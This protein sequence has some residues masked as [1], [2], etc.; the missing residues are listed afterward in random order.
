VALAILVGIGGG[1]AF[2]AH[3][4]AGRGAKAVSGTRVAEAKARAAKQGPRALPREMRGVH[5]TMA[6][7]SLHGKL[8]EYV[9]LRRAGLNTIELDVKD[10]NGEVG[11]VKG[12]PALA[13][14][15]GAAKPYYNARIAAR[16]VHAADLYLIG[17][18]VTFQDPV[19]SERRPGLAL[20]DPDGAV[21]HTRAGFGW[22][23][24]YDRR[25]WNYDV[26]VATAA[27]H[28]GFDEIQF[29]Y[30][31]FPS[32]GDVSA[33]RYPVRTNGSM[34][35]TITQFVRYA[36]RILRKLHVRVSVDVFG[37]AATRDLGIGQK[38]QR[39]AHYVDAVYPM[40][41]PSHF[42]PGEYGLAD[43][44]ANPGQTVTDALLYFEAALRGTNARLVPWLQDFSLG[45]T[46]TKA[47]LRAQ[48]DA[49]RSLDTRGFLLWNPVGLY[50][51][52]ALSGT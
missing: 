9:A 24:P 38:P 28:A 33:I 18:I 25:V 40:V 30:V 22:L 36:S 37:L 39:L 12:A 8:D 43:P 44:N 45:R 46:Y 5:V 2:G 11:F 52:A 13:R 32:D 4:L 42:N 27:A 47:D 49:A 6:L 34:A 26:A 3:S 7:A 31:R 51:P 16:Q 29:D 17:R 19:L 35:R 1:F 50:T 15:V 23:N 10:E 20:H 21:W 48:V 14:R 41:Y